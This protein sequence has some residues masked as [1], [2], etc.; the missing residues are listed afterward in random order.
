MASL[1]LDFFSKVLGKQTNVNV[2]LPD[3][4]EVPVNGWRTIVLL[5]GWSENYT[6]WMRNTSIER[7]AMKRQIAVIMP[8]GGFSFYNDMAYG[9]KYLTYLT[10][11]LPKICNKYFRTSLLREDNF[12]GGLSMGGCGA[13]TVGLTRPDLYAGLICL[14]ATNFPADGFQAQYDTLKDTEWLQ[15]MKCIYG[16]IFPHLVGTDYD[17]YHLAGKIVSKGGPYPTIFHY[18]GLD[19]TEGMEWARRMESVFLGFSGNP[20]HYKLVTYPG[21]HTWDSWDAHIC[22]GLD[23]LGLAEVPDHCER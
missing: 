3:A 17:A 12:I 22:E 14:S 6:S 10:E 2:I 15:S 9:L 20:F 8:D 18:M 7:Y 21:I 1:T 13:L 11:E 23:Y 5:H 4:E 16:E 19:E